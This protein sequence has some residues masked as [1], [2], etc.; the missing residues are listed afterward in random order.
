MTRRRPEDRWSHTLAALL[1]IPG[2][3]AAAHRR[4][5]ERAQQGDDTPPSQPP[6]SGTDPDLR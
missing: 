2:E 1:H 3:T 4:A 6:A 5:R